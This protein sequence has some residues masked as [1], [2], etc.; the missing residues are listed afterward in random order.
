MPPARQVGPFGFRP[1]LE[2]PMAP[3]M[4]SY[5]SLR[6]QPGSA[7]PGWSYDV[8]PM[9]HRPAVPWQ[10][11]PW[12]RGPTPSLSMPNVPNYAPLASS[13]LWQGRPDT[14]LPF[15]G[16]GPQPYYPEKQ[17]PYRYFGEGTEA[18]IVAMQAARRFYMLRVVAG[19]I[20]T[21]ALGALLLVLM[22]PSV[23]TTSA[24]F[25]GSLAFDCRTSGEHAEDAWPQSQKRYCCSNAGR[26]CPTPDVPA[27]QEPYDC[28]PSFHNWHGGWSTAKQEWCCR[29]KAQGC[30][31]QQATVTTS[32]LLPFDCSA[33]FANWVDG[34]A[35][36][37]KAWCCEHGGR[38]CASPSTTNSPPPTTPSPS[39][40]PLPPSPLP[41]A[42]PAQYD[43]NDRWL[44]WR[45]AWAAEKKAWCC[46][47]GGKGCI[48]PSTTSTSTTTAQVTT[49]QPTNTTTQLSFDCNRG[50]SNWPTAWSAHQQAWCCEH[51]GKGCSARPAVQ[52][53]PAAQSSNPAQ[54]KFDCLADFAD[55]K[56]AWAEQKK[57]WCCEKVRKGC[58]G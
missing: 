11:G 55:W 40:R 32:A 30:D 33:G 5:A 46:Q 54:L 41:P 28:L 8:N 48:P 58:P 38:G 57:V 9:L 16:L 37:K 1:P 53:T 14:G 39:P 52:P 20:A 35:T 12:Q 25:G 34:W 43:C 45:V 7:I 24:G 27:D 42:P 56:E 26:G 29:V 10:G 50:F 36:N 6:R 22:W 13:R 31:P 18:E 4:P 51:V 21:L 3:G 44:N 2:Y 15:T 47:H 17:Y 49:H 23:A 19:L